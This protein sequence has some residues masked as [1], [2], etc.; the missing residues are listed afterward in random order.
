MQTT[1]N[2]WDYSGKNYGIENILEKQ[3]KRPRNR[4]KNNFSVARKRPLEEKESY[5][6]IEAVKEIQKLWQSAELDKIRPKIIH[7][8]D[9]EGDIAEVFEQVSQTINT[10]VVVRAAHNRAIEESDSYLWQW[11]PDQPIK[12]EVA[13]KLPKTKKRSE[14]TAKLAIR[15]APIL[16]S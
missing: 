12:I 2:Q 13:V 4:R 1:G 3:L 8:F 11:L 7:V 5:K 6:W 16:P 10:G 14:R 9:R 15:Y